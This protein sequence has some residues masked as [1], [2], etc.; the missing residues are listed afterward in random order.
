MTGDETHLLQLSL[1]AQLDVRDVGHGGGHP[2]Q[3]GPELGVEGGVLRA[4]PALPDVGVGDDEGGP[5][6]LRR[7]SP[8]HAERPCSTDMHQSALIRTDRMV[9]S[10]LGSV[11]TATH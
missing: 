6:G 11:P 9:P 7:Q 1:G 10:R 3:H 4:A 2:L 8:V 5:G